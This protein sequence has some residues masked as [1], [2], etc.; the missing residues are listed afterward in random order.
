MESAATTASP[1]SFRR[2]GDGGGITWRSPPA[3]QLRRSIRLTARKSSSS[4]SPTIRAKALV[5]DAGGNEAA[6]ATAKKLSIPVI[7]LSLKLQRTPPGKFQLVG[8]AIGVETGDRR[9]LSLMTSPL[10]AN[11]GHD[12]AAEDGAAQPGEHRRL[13]KN[14]RETLS[15]TPTD[16]C[17]NIMP[18][19]H[20]H[21]LIA[22]SPLAVG[23]RL[24]V[25]HAGFNALKF[26]QWLDEAKPTW[27]TAVPTMHQCGSSD[28]RRATRK[29]RPRKTAFHPLASSSL[30]PPGDGVSW[31]YLRLPGIDPTA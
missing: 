22:A 17:L 31:S 12:V 5:P 14:I 28:G 19:F 15:L 11:Y 3:R 9:R 25:L 6:E 21:G 27:Y 8:E 29:A 1:S 23:G 2:T 4:I 24:G 13:A 16:R 10:C 18:L 30:P 7:R 26:F 20:I